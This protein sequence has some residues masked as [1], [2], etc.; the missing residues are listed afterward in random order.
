MV[1]SRRRRINLDEWP[2][3]L[4][5]GRDLVSP[6][7]HPTVGVFA[8]LHY[9]DEEYV[10]VGELVMPE[11]FWFLLNPKGQRVILRLHVVEGVLEVDAVTLVRRPG[12]APLSG[13]SLRSI[14]LPQ[15]V[16]IA[17]MRAGGR[18]VRG[19]FRPAV[20]GPSNETDHAKFLAAVQKDKAGLRA[21]MPRRGKRL[22]D[23]TLER[24][25]LLYR[26]ALAQ[27]QPPTKYVQEQMQIAASTAGR[28][29]M[30]TRRR[31]FLGP[32]RPGV[33]GEKGDDSG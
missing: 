8:V 24:V 15:L 19:K 3:A 20:L 28:Y 23:A 9:A 21:H 11:R 22:D 30:Q 2:I 5:P 7:P 16:E 33:P 1:R 31:G 26:Q 10:H 29:V 25:A 14:H 17:G 27:G 12:E 13:A 18:I 6:F 4:E 32:T